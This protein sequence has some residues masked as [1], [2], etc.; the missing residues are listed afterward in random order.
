MF[1]DPNR[2]P[3]QYFVFIDEAGDPGLRTLRPKDPNGSSEWFTLG[4]VVVSAQNEPQTVGWVREI[5]NAVRQDQRPDLHYRNLNPKRRKRACEMLATKETRLFAI[6]SHKLNM[7]GYKNEKASK[8]GAQDPF[9]NWC[10]RILLERVTMWIRQRS[11]RDYGEPRLAQIVFSNRGGLRY[12]QLIAYHEYLRRQSSNGSLYLNRGD[13]SWDVLHPDLYSSIPHVKS[14]GCQLADIVASAFYHA[15]D[16]RA[17]A[18]DCSPAI[19]LGPR[20]GRRGKSTANIGLTLLPLPPRRPQ[21]T[22]DQAAIF[23]H[24]GYNL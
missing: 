19:A 11:I 14:A 18:W 10:V 2:A 6:A 7:Q 16:A 5:K 8:I 3:P 21:L 4:A 20:L 12:T 15:A 17:K 1:G 22:G 23:N 13:I 9:Y 24:F